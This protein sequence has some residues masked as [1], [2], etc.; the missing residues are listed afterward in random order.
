MDA[1]VGYLVL[2]EINSCYFEEGDGEEGRT[3]NTWQ[4][5]KGGNER[6]QGN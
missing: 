6:Q 2:F 4:K 3:E 1:A 5:K